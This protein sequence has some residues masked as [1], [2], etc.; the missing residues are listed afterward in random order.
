VF[1]VV[2]AAPVRMRLQE[3]PGFAIF[4]YFAVI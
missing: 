4:A 1:F 2:T 3:L